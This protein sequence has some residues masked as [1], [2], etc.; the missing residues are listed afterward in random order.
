MEMHC[1][2]IK[3]TMQLVLGH[4]TLNE[5]RIAKELR[6]IA[7]LLFYHV[8]S[9]EKF[10]KCQPSSFFRFTA[11]ETALFFRGF[12]FLEGNYL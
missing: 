4:L 6:V 12:Y 1:K 3:R 8:K 11:V 2:K 5:R 9:L 10:S 7:K